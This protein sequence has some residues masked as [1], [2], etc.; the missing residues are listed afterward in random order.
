MYNNLFLKVLLLFFSILQT[1]FLV[2]PNIGDLPQE[3]ILKR[4]DL[5]LPLIMPA[6]YSFTIWAAILVLSIMYSIFYFFSNTSELSLNNKIA[7][8]ALGVFIS[9]SIYAFI[10]RFGN[11]NILFALALFPI[12][13]FLV[14]ILILI[15]SHLKEKT[16]NYRLANILFSI[17]CGWVTVLFTVSFA[18]LLINFGYTG[19][20][21]GEK[22]MSFV[23]LL[24]ITLIVTVIYNKTK[25]NLFLGS[26][27]WGV[28]GILV[29]SILINQ[30][31]V[32]ISSMLAIVL[33]VSYPFFART[34]KY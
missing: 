6:D 21:I 10:S 18:S 23:G 22:L 15:S 24:I 17:Y 26:S 27:L 25:N 1:L 33:F 11:L 9:G 31:E 13:M 12:L 28:I 19:F 5:R 34:S 4:D 16:F 29:N 8:Y 2:I 14:R 32:F 20:P 3:L 7:P 30:N